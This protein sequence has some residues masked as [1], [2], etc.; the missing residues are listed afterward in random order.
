[1]N[2]KTFCIL[3]CT[4]G[5]MTMVGDWFTLRLPKTRKKNFSKNSKEQTEI[6]QT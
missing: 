6:Y 5:A 3:Y 4:V 1:M 2:G